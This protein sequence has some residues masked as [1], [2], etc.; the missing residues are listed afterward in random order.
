MSLI[1]N[2]CNVE[3]PYKVIIDDNRLMTIGFKYMKHL[4]C[5]QEEICD[6]LDDNIGHEGLFWIWKAHI[7]DH[8]YWGTT[9]SFKKESDAVHFKLIWG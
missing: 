9:I 5:L 2:S 7:V 8:M 4:L 6:W 1:Q 3:M